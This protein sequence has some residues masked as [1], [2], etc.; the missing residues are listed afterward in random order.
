MVIGT[1][2]TTM[3]QLIHHVS[4]RVLWWNIKSPMRPRPLQPRFGTLWLLTFPKTKITFEREEISDHQW[5]SGKYDGAAHGNWEN[6]EVPRCLFWRGLRCHC[7]MYNVSCVFFSKC[8]FFILHGWI[9]SGQTSYI[10]C[11]FQYRPAYDKV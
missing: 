3:C 1:F 10:W 9:S 11:F 7:S 2:I 4:C 8:L 5:N 6:C